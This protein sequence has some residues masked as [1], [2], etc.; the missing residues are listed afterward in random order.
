M[1]RTRKDSVRNASTVRVFEIV[2]SHEGKVDFF[3]N[4]KKA[5]TGITKDYLAQTLCRNW[6]FC[7]EELQPIL[8][9]LN[10]KGAVTVRF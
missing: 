3:Q 9:D 8:E 2:R 6:G 1:A 4:G 7:G 10:Q 5:F